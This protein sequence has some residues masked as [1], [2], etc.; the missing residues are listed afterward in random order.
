MKTYSL[1][2]VNAERQD[3]KLHAGGGFDHCL[4]AQKR[5]KTQHPDRFTAVYPEA[6]TK[7]RFPELFPD[8]T[9]SYKVHHLAPPIL[10]RGADYMVTDGVSDGDDEDQVIGW[11]KTE[12]EAIENYL[13]QL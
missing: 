9:P 8:P 1:I 5:L 10:F 12:Q 11:G 4:A 2:S 3:R 7:E 13:D 6:I